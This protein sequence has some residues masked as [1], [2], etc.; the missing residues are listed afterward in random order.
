MSSG[1]W[2]TMSW[3][4]FFTFEGIPNLPKMIKWKITQ[5]NSINRLLINK[6]MLIT[7]CGSVLCWAYAY[8]CHYNYS[9][10]HFFPKTVSRRSTRKQI[11]WINTQ[12]FI[13]FNNFQH[14]PRTILLTTWIFDAIYF[15]TTFLFTNHNV[16][17][18]VRCAKF[19]ACFH[20]SF[21]VFTWIVK[22][23][24][25]VQTGNTN[26]FQRK[27]VLWSLTV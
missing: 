5:L 8:V 15:G 17:H 20:I 22:Y 12:Q 1:C 16:G 3:F 25:F 19:V 21:F 10:F 18:S 11:I 13:N 27:D 2:E 9:L 4:F 26:L 23:L 7:S 24:P 14:V 6:K